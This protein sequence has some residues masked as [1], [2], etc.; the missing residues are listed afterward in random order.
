MLRNLQRHQTPVVIAI[1]TAVS[2]AIE[3]PLGFAIGAVEFPSAWTSADLGFQFS[4]DGGTTFAD[5]LDGAGTT[6]A[7][8]RCTGV[9]TA[10]VSF[11]LVPI[12]LHELSLG[13]QVKFTS[14][15]VASNAAVN[16][17]AAR[18]LTCWVG[19]AN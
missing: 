18:T 16:Q 10:A 11:V 2:N 17:A 13:I 9:P 5:V 12:K 15:N 4:T 14:I 6:T 3:I 1:N 19:R 7:F 8:L